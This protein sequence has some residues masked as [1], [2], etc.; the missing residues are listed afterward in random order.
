MN[1]REKRAIIYTSP[2][3]AAGRRTGILRKVVFTMTNKKFYDLLETKKGLAE[4]RVQAILDRQ[5]GIQ[6]ERWLDQEYEH[7]V[8][9]IE[10]AWHADGITEDEYNGH[11][12]SLKAWKADTAEFLY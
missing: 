11:Y 12:E 8:A 3:G 2:R 1:R 9:Y 4:E 10:G 5:D 6:A 7:L